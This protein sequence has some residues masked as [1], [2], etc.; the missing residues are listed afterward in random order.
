[1]TLSTRKKKTKEEFMEIV[2]NKTPELVEFYS[3]L[4]FA[5]EENINIIEVDIEKNTV[6]VED[7]FFE[8]KENQHFFL[9]A[10]ADVAYLEISSQKK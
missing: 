7:L 2:K 8:L 9:N 5:N 4:Q 3:R 1:M 10:E 6:S